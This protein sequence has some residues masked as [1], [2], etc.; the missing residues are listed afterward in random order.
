M[1][2]TTPDYSNNPLTPTQ[3]TWSADG[4]GFRTTLSN[5]V[6]GSDPTDYVTFTV[7]VGQRLTSFELSSYRSSDGVAFI[8]L[9]RSSSITGTE[10][11][12]TPFS[13]YTH[14]GSSS[15]V[16]V[17]TNLIAA[18]GGPLQ[19]GSYSAWIQQVGAST[20]YSF[21][22]KTVQLMPT[23]GLTATSTSVNEGAN[24]VFTLTTTYVSAGTVLTYKLSGVTESDIAGG[25]LTGT[26]TVGA[27]GQGTITVGIAADL[28]TDGTDTLKVTVET[29]SATVAI[30]D[31]SKG[32]YLNGTSAN[33]KLVGEISNDTLYGN[34]GDDTLDGG[35]G[36]DYLS[37]GDGSDS[38]IGGEGDDSITGGSGNDTIAGGFSN[39][40]IH[41]GEGLDTVIFSSRRESYAVST[42]AQDSVSVSFEGPIIAIYPPPPTDGTDTLTSVERIQFSDRTLAMDLNSS[43]GNAARLLATV[44]GKDALKNPTYAGIAI[45]LFDQGYSKDQV[46]QV[47][48][49]AVFGA[50][51]KSKDI[52]SMIWKNL[53]GSDID[54]KNLA[55]LSGL[56]DSK[57]ITAAQLATKAADLDLT[58]QVIDLVGLSK[59]GW[60]YIPYGG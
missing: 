12:T 46:S 59:T 5:T 53:T 47:A 39:D 7:P 11:N 51:P 57:A 10:S 34:A 43:A 60:E 56:I 33:D 8:A 15:S 32:I 17:G 35:A 31:T 54:S 58:A 22:L 29:A 14:F 37:G 30:A 4:T 18:F 3:V 23:Y 9:Q 36:N 55:D 26:V 20:D 25:V 27:N 24:A 28:Q 41:G 44:F 2:D 19:A 6:G 1:A 52:V 42:P 49:N 16:N 45:S 40:T 21:S 38:I 13:G 48:L 50:N